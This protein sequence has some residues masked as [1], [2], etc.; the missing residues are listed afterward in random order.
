MLALLQAPPNRSFF[1]GGCTIYE[2]RPTE[3][4]DVY[5]ACLTSLALGPEWRPNKCKMFVRYEGNL[6]AIHVDPSDPAAWRREPFFQQIKT[7]LVP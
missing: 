7:L 6:V 3:C 5:C 4:R 1:R 2:T